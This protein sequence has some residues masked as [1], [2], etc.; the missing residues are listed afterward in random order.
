[1][2]PRLLSLAHG[3]LAHPGGAAGAEG[4]AVS[5]AAVCEVLNS[6]AETTHTPMTTETTVPSRAELPVVYQAAI[7]ALAECARLDECQAWADKAKALASYAKQADDE[8][9][10]KYADRIKARA[11][12]RLGVLL[13]EIEPQPGKRTDLQPADGAVTRSQA[14]TDAGISERQRVTALRVASVPEDDFERQVESDTP[15]TIT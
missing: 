6:A 10:H 4:A 5:A 12:R 15:P 7:H 13:K 11:I 8:T 14:A 3:R 2:V 1:M 9:L